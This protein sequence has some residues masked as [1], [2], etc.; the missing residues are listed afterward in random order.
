L[1]D[2]RS[3]AVT[4]SAMADVLSQQ[5]KLQE[6]M[7]LFEQS[8]RTKRE[9]GDLRGVAA[10]Q[11]AMAKVLSQQGKAQEAMALF[12]QSLRTTQ[13]LGDVR[14]VAVTQQAMADVLSQQGKLQEAMALYEQSLRTMRE[15]GDLREVA[16]T[17]SAMAD[18]LSQQGKAQEAI[19]F[20]EQSLRTKRELGDLRVVAVTQANFCQLLLQ[21]G[22]HDRALPM[23]WEAYTSLSRNHYTHDAQIMQELLISIKGEALGSEQFDMIWKQV[24]GEPQPSWLRSVQTRVLDE[25]DRLSTGSLNV[26]VFNTAAVMTLMPE[27]LAEWRETMGEA[28]KQAQNTH[29]S[30]DV[31]FFTAILALLDG[32]APT[33]PEEHPY[34]DAFHEIQEGIASGGPQD[35]GI[36]VDVSE[37]MMQAVRDFVNADDWDATRQVVEA[38]QVLLFRPEVVALFEWNVA[39]AR[40]AGE[41]R[42]VTVLEQHLALLRNCKEI[43]IAE[44]FEQLEAVQEDDLL[45]DVELI[46]RSI[47]ALLGGPQEKLA[48]AQYLTAQT[49]QAADDNL[50]AL[51]NTIQL[52]LFSSDL[53]QLGRDLHGVYHQ[54]WETI[55]VG[56]ETGG[57]DPRLFEMIT[58]NTLAM[59]GPASNRRSEWRNSLVEMRNAAMAQGARHFV[60][61]LDAVIGLLDAGGNL[62]GLGEGLTGVYAKTWQKI[63]E[64]LPM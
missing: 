5:G 13:E 46:P 3:V 32:Q 29:Q 1:G 44:A 45:F 52:A 34:A 16:V 18:V 30:H 12:E 2:V 27:K 33:L 62:A 56:V 7:A 15:L 6:A 64:R 25:Q 60:M 58:S 51:I 39:Q 53:S 22:E 19:A 50:K 48:H 35:E 47:A 23:A 10:T 61:L 21:Q 8:L 26:M 59:L 14:S 57:V 36:S 49:A 17:Q 20:Y 55:V 37:E 4:Q 28:L 40:A 63:V 24:I 11:H 42:T 54:A 9:L 38:Q 43:G 31:E 41:Q